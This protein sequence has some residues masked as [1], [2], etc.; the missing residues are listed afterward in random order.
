MKEMS[1]D[2]NFTS[3]VYEYYEVRTLWKNKHFGIIHENISKSSIIT[4][5]LTFTQMV[6][7]KSDH[8][9]DSQFTVCL[10]PG[11]ESFLLLVP[12]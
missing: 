9:S 3:K 8:I 1:G 7:I 12:E 2:E 6:N 10:A 5:T 11:Q 4:L